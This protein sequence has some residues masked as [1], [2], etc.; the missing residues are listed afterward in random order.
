LLQLNAP[1]W[2]TISDTAKDLVQKMLIVD[3]KRRITIHDVLNHKWVRDRDRT[4]Q[5]GHLIDTVEEMKKMNTRR[6]LK[7]AV[8][9]AVSSP[10]WAM[11]S[12]MLEYGEDEVTS[13]GN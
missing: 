6:K 1:Q 5:K 10:K 8:M 3:Q 13:A 9:A 4:L 2:D 7:G 12:D 11:S